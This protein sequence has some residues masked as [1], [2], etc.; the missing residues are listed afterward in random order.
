MAEI[1]HASAT[2]AGWEMEM[3]S[4]HS[5]FPFRFARTSSSSLQHSSPSR[6]SA[7]WRSAQML[8]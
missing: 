4:L 8:F 6:C 1:E 3:L 7:L 5:F 2:F